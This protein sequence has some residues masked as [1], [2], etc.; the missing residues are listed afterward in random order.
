MR[1]QG[2]LFDAPMTTPVETASRWVL[3]TLSGS[4]A[5]ALA[6]V[7]VA[8]LGILMLRGRLPV[9]DGGM[10]AVGC[11]LL[12]G[13]STLAAALMVSGQRASLA[14]AGGPIAAAPYAPDLPPPPPP[15]DYDPYEGASIR[16]DQR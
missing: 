4:L 2:S 11:F 5:T 13:A 12:F 6:V 3:G 9:R 8:L 16:Q 1:V 10:V 15:A 14:S 7:A